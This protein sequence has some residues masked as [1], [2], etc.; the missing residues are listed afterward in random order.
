MRRPTAR[1]SLRTTARST[2]A[3]CGFP[4]A[5]AGIVPMPRRPP[6]RTVSGVMAIIPTV[7]RVAPADG[8]AAGR[9][10]DRVD[11]RDFIRY[12]LGRDRAG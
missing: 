2:R 5:L 9:R 11:I 3:D 4:D 12:G 10:Q 8:F 7:T 6:S 1:A